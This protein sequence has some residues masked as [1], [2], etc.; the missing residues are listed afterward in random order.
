MVRR[1][2]LCS[3]DPNQE[4]PEKRTFKRNPFAEILASRG[5]YIAAVL[6]VARAYLSAGEPP[7]SP[8]LSHSTPGRASSKSH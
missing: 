1:T 7:H 6:A 8:S 5:K 3:I 4:A 2:L